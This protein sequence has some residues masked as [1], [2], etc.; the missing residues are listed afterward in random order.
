MNRQGF[1]QI[2]QTTAAAA[3]ADRMLQRKCACGNH[4]VAR[5]ECTE[6]GKS[7]NNLQRKEGNQGAFGARRS[8]SRGEVVQT[9]LTIGATND[10]LEQEADRVADQV[11][12]A[13]VQ[14][15][16]GRADLHI[17]RLAE[18]TT[19]ATETAPASVDRALAGPGNPLEPAVQQDMQQ[20]FGHDFSRVRVHCG[21][22]AEQSAR[23]VNA[24]AYTVGHHVVFGSGQFAP[25][26]PGGRRLLAHELTHV[27][28]QSG[29][30]GIHDAQ[31]NEKR[32]LS[33]VST[34]TTRFNYNID[35]EEGLYET[36]LSGETPRI[37]R[38][39]AARLQRTATWAAGTETRGWDAADRTLNGGGQLGFTPPILNG[40]TI[41]SAAAA[42]AAI[43]APTFTAQSVPAPDAGAPSS[44]VSFTANA[45]NTASYHLDAIDTGPHSVGSTK[46]VVA[47]RMTALGSTAPTQCTGSDPTT[48]SINGQPD[49]TTHSAAILTHER[50]HATDHQ[51]Q[52]TNVIGAWNTAIDAAVAANTAFTG[53]TQPAAEANMWAAVGGTPSQIATNQ[54]NAWMTAN[55][56]FHASAAGKAKRPFN[57]QADATCANS[58]MDHTA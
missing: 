37:A 42:T 1:V 16:G 22:A 3:S 33:P 19:G 17:Q 40:S 29:A 7:K 52:F 12:A 28:Q 34:E 58:S 11:L 23:E 9:K 41:L 10:P 57:A 2:N 47:A 51:A 55:N 54:H 6:C 5:G 39:P 15:G 8:L 44:K 30:D 32:D 36:R 35:R 24:H 53:P 48:F 31:R 46:A 14:I 20:R 49:N 27:V 13:P 4:T 38:A 21:A 26:T 50:H 45:T 18:Q 25:T 56:N 43:K